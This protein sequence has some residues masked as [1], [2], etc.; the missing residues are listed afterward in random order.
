MR[1]EFEVA[2][3]GLEGSVSGAKP[4]N[5]LFNAASISS[6]SADLCD[7]GIYTQLW[8]R[9]WTK[10]EANKEEGI[11]YTVLTELHRDQRSDQR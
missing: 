10:K 4:T 1:T 11:S 6:Q 5:F 8:L 3:H 2:Q 9:K 7:S